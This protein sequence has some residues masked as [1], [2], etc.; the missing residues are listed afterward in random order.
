MAGE[1]QAAAKIRA[2]FAA[3]A[4]KTKRPGYRGCPFT[5]AIVEFPEPDHPG[6]K[7]AAANKQEQR[8]RLRALAA[9]TGAADPDELGDQ[10]FLLMEGAYV[11]D[12][13]TGPTRPAESLVSA[14]EMLLAM[15]VM[16]QSE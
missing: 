2:L 7:I 4:E 12:T 3:V 6:R 14:A 16:G 13:L 15:Q 5:N 10:L 1:R 9:E 11:S 8:R